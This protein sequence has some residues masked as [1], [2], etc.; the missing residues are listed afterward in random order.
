MLCDICENLGTL[1]NGLS[2]ILG[3]DF[4]QTS[5]VI[6]NGNSASIVNTYIQKYTL[7]FKL[8]QPILRKNMRLEDDKVNAKFA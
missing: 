1:L 4:A 8:K 7:W 6:W 2:A 3:G 5:P